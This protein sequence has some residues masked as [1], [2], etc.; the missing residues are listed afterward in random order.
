M[1]DNNGITISNITANAAIWAPDE[2]ATV[3]FKFKNGSGSKILDLKIS[4]ILMAKDFTGAASGSDIVLANVVGTEFIM[5]RVNLANGKSKTYSA[6]FA[7]SGAAE[8]YFEE[9]AGVRAVPIYIRYTAADSSG[10]FAST[11]EL[12]G[13]KALN[14]RFTPQIAE[15]NLVRAKDG[16]PNDE[17][18]NVLTTLKLGVDT[19]NYDYTRFMAAKIYTNQGGD[20]TTADSYIDIT[21]SIPSLLSGAVNNPDLIPGTYDKAYDWDFLLVYGDEYEAFYGRFNLGMAFANL[22]LSG[23]STGGACFGGFSTSSYKKPKL[24]SH[25]PI[26]AYKGIAKLGED[27]EILTPLAGTTPAEFGGGQLRCRKV[28][29][30]RIVEGSLMVKPGSSTLVLAALPD[31]YTPEKGVFSINACEGGRVA[32]I[33]VGGYGEE[34]AGKLCMSWVKNLTDGSNYTAAAI[35][36]QCSIEYWVEAPEDDIVSTANL[37]DSTGAIVTDVTGREIAVRSAGGEPYQSVYT[38][39]QIDDGITAANNAASRT[40]VDDAISEI[41]LLP[42]PAGPAGP[43]GATGATGPAGPSGTDGSPGKS[44]YEYAQEGGYEGTEEEFAEDLGKVGTGGIADSVA[45]ENVTGKPFGDIITG[46]AVANGDALTWDGD[47]KKTPLC[48]DNGTIFKFYY[49]SENLPSHADL[50]AG[51]ECERIRR[52]DGEVLTGGVNLSIQTDPNHE[53]EVDFIYDAVVG[54]TRPYIY[55]IRKP[56]GTGDGYRFPRAGIYFSNYTVQFVSKLTISGYTFTQSTTLTGIDT[57]LTQPSRPADAKAVGEAVFPISDAFE[58]SEELGEIVF[59]GYFD[60]EA[61]T[62]IKDNITGLNY[63]RVSDYAPPISVLQNGCTVTIDG[64]DTYFNGFT[65]AAEG[66]CCIGSSVWVVEKDGV[67]ASDGNK[68]TFFQYKGTYFL[69]LNNDAYVTKLTSD[70]MQE[71]AKKLMLKED[72]IPTISELVMCSPAGKKFRITIDNNGNLVPTEI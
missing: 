54:T 36:V 30:K 63:F 55:I 13:L 23:V 21:G 1:T 68:S 65:Y 48:V 9:N 41:E 14:H 26:Y 47:I 70:S 29:N 72:R 20:A 4:I 56:T 6:S 42:G 43:S 17:G 52:T 22:H 28:E 31:G 24:E 15:M 46:T 11:F 27:W 44:A 40:Y 71:N 60:T 34:N 53:N 38:G 51:F 49:V 33:V 57:T 39:K 25:Y 10:S 16:I 66:Y 35:W 37:I 7:I 3:S 2:P 61:A 64:K 69:A 32:R 59:D 19:G 50:E 12:E 67:T 8:Q 18:E 5:E 45:W 58:K 62:V